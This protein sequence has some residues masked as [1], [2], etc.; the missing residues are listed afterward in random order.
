MAFE[1]QIAWRYLFSR[2]RV[3]AINIVSGVS[4]AAVTVVTAAMICV[5]SVMNGFGSVVEQMFSRFNPQL[6]VVASQAKTFSVSDPA[7]R[8]LYQNPDIEIV[9]QVLEQTA[10]I[11]Y[12]DKQ[13]PARL[14]GV[15][16]LFAAATEIDSI[17]TD[18]S[19]L[20]IDEGGFERSVLGRGLASTIGVGAH[21]IEPV[22]IYAPKRT[23]RVNLMRPDKSFKREH[24]FIAGTFAVNQ[25]QYDDQL[26]IASLPLVRRLYDYDSLT[27]SSL[28]IRLRDPASLSKTKKA[29]RSSLG[30]AYRVLDRYE[31]QEDF[32]HILR[33][34]KLLTA[35][36][37]VFILLIASFNIISSLTMLIIDKR[38]GIRT[39]S[40]LGASIWQIRRIFLYEGWLISILGAVLGIIFGVTICLLQQHF[41]FV[42][43][44]SGEDYILSA[45]PVVVDWMDI[46]FVGAVVLLL[47]FVAAYIPVRRLKIEQ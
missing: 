18:G 4:A 42:K 15:D 10:L 23:G 2:K 16:S 22:Y 35:L 5:L 30:D 47:G 25:V 40:H 29:L 1:A 31:Q 44:G 32:F 24:T 8:S 26:I 38:E 21:F 11:R 45:Y 39:L 36:L 6:E 7:I 34:E 17:I 19:F 43:L 28:H 41:G 12:K 33:V 46:V 14:M 27:V 37:L 13:T 20:L 9:S 3:S